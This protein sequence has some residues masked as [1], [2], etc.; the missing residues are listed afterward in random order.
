M[1][2][3]AVYFTQPGFNAYPFN[4]A[5]YADGYHKLAELVAERGGQL[6]L[7]RGQETYR[8]GNTF[9]GG[10]EFRDG[11]FH[12]FED[13]RTFDLIFNKG[14]LQGDDNAV[15]LNDPEL[16]T[17]CTDKALT[18]SMFEELSPT[19]FFVKSRDEL[20]EA[21]EKI[22]SDIAVA[23]PV[24]GEEGNGVYIGPHE[25][26]LQ[27]VPRFPYLV[28]ELIDTDGGIPGIAPGRHDFRMIVMNGEVIYAFVRMPAEGKYIANVA[29]GGDYAVV[30]LSKIPPD[31]LKIVQR[32]DRE[33]TRFPKR[34]YSVDVGLDRASA[35]KVIELNAQPGLSIH[36]YNDSPQGKHLFEHVATLL[37]S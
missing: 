2:T 35:W 8:K 4:K 15:I 32:I 29:Q 20:K 7:V 34:I 6:S 26:V 10:W 22:T 5:E 27:K 12:R 33:F 14:R 13:D 23:K 3:I 11:T 9:A 16:D 31:T 30:P 36:D 18:Y 25:D 28:Q 19:T 37:A 17:I 24:D 21:L 1:K